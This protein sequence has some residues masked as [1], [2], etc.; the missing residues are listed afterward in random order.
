MLFAQLQCRVSEHSHFLLSGQIQILQQVHDV[1]WG[2][3]CLDPGGE[4][5]FRLWL[6][7]FLILFMRTIFYPIR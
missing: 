2:G 7:K 4:E 3:L 1:V 6:E 5:V